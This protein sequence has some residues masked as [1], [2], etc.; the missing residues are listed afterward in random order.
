M[1]TINEDRSVYVTR[2]DILFFKVTADN[3]GEA[4]RFQPGDVIR[5]TVY[6]KKAC[7]C[8]VLQK[9]F[10]IMEESLF[11]DIFLT[12]EET[13]IGSLINKPVDY[14]YEIELNPRTN[15]QT[16]VGYDED[17]AKV[18]RLFPEGD[19]LEEPAPDIE[20]EDIPIIDGELDLLS[21]R[22]VENRVVSAAIVRINERSKTTDLYARETAEATRKYI[23]EHK[24]D[25][26]NPH[27]VT[28]AQVGLGNVPN[29]ETNDQTPTYEQAAEISEL[30]SGER[31][32]VAFGKLKKAVSSMISHLGNKDNPHA[33]TAAQAGARP[34]TWFPNASEVG[35]APASHTEDTNNPHKVTAAQAGA[36][37]DDWMP[38]AEEVGA[39]PASHAEDKE[40]PHKVTA[41]QAG[42]RPDTWLPTPEEI[43]AV[44][45]EGNQQVNG[46][47]FT[48]NAAEDGAGVEFVGKCLIGGKL[49]SLHIGVPGETGAAQIRY[50][51]NGE[52]KSNI[53]MA[54]RYITMQNALD[55]AGGGTGGTTKEEARK[56]LGFT[57]MDVL[58][59]KT[60]DYSG[61]LDVTS[62]KGDY[63]A[64]EAIMV[65]FDGH[66]DGK[67]LC[68]GIIPRHKSGVDRNYVLPYTS[69]SG[70]VYSREVLFQEDKIAFTEGYKGDTMDLKAC[71]PVL[72][73]G[74]KTGTTHTLMGGDSE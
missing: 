12:E 45:T 48:L 41:K 52:V 21:P 57:S 10:P 23:D 65:Y 24:Q 11:V 61:G 49:H 14:W 31:L 68:S 4:Y 42:A 43:K 19:K 46:N 8:V 5:M 26:E 3:G 33:V 72:V 44:G 2:G 55:V 73:Y 50:L 9:D 37:P 40:N 20:P 16:I 15:P 53:I 67:M 66:C 63:A 60:D 51:V 7:N 54:D 34:D 30:T 56:N 71:V 58:W 28:K 69:R 35:A 47:S 1:F 74:L 59:E 29:V 38:T 64:Y 27:A 70:N 22:P 32:A 62:I 18:F 13:R 39:V 17:G 6:E 36:R 25:K